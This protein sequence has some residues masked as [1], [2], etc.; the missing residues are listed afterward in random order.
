MNLFDFIINRWHRKIREFRFRNWLIFMKG[1]KFKTMRKLGRTCFWRY[2]P[3]TKSN[4]AL[5]I[6]HSSLKRCISTI[7]QIHPSTPNHSYLISQIGKSRT[8]LTTQRLQIRSIGWKHSFVHE[9]TFHGNGNPLL[10]VS[11]HQWYTVYRKWVES[12]TFTA[13]IAVIF[14]SAPALSF[15]LLF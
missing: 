14:G 2:W 8:R 1:S 13:K 9:T 5:R 11:S 6:R 12:W 4:P 10:W 7:I 15:G 3:M